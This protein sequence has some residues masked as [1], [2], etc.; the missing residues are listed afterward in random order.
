M[1]QEAQA[2]PIAPLHRFFTESSI[3]MAVLD[4]NGFVVEANEPFRRSFESLS[5]R[6]L[7]DME[8][9]FPEF[10]RGRDAFRFA[11]HFSRL[12]SGATRSA[13]FDTPFRNATAVARHLNIRAWAIDELPDAPPNRRSWRTRRRSTRQAGGC[14]K[15]RTWPSGPWR[16]RAS[17]WRT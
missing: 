8:E 5:G 7:E 4:E 17:S 13:T 11:Y 9:S 10:L 3:A 14:R 12:I 15:Q 2:G 1:E 6:G 16:P